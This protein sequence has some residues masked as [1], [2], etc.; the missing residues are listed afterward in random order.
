MITHRYFLISFVL[1]ASA[2]IEIGDK[3]RKKAAADSAAATVTA[4][5]LA[6]STPSWDTLYTDTIGLGEQYAKYMTPASESTFKLITPANAAAKPTRFPLAVPTR[7]STALHLQILLDRAGFSPGIIDATW[8]DNAVK[9]LRWF[10][11]GNADSAVAATDST[12]RNIDRATYNR[13]ADSAGSAPLITSYTVTDADVKGPFTRIPDRVYDQAKLSCLCYSSAAEEL[14]ERFHASQSL[15]AQLN[16]GVR[17]ESIT[18]GTTISVPN[19]G[20]NETSM[21][22]TATRPDT[23]TPRY[24]A[25]T[26]SAE[27]RI[28]ISKK[29]SWTHLVDGSGKTIRHFPS[30]LGAGYDPSPTGEF[31]VTGI[32]RN[33]AFRYDPKL[34]A[35]VPDTRPT[36]KLPPGPNSPVGIVWIA[37]S[38]PHYGIHGTAAPE[39]IGYQSSHGCVRLTNWDAR[40]LAALVSGGTPVTF[41]N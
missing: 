4:D 3:D 17:F 18:A 21:A 25:D 27:M 2:C 19:V 40:A 28:V 9:A 36:A 6:I 15:L 30:T 38:K 14:A 35:E 13:L 1:A 41:Q 32:S 24:T 22:S 8:G 37:L 26:V 16:P 34:F 11:G 33:P 5:S 31:H 20:G 12:S 29:E 7:G 23:S 39:S 10:N